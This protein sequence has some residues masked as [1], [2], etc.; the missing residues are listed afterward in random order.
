LEGYGGQVE[1]GMGRFGLLVGFDEGSVVSIDGE[2]VGVGVSS[3]DGGGVGMSSMDS[4]REGASESGIGV[5]A[6]VVL[7]KALGFNDGLP[8]AV[9]VGISTGDSGLFGAV[10][11]GVEVLT[12][13]VGLCGASAGLYVGCPVSNDGGSGGGDGISSMGSVLVGSA[14]LG[15]RD[16]GRLVGEE[17]R[18]SGFE[19][20]VLVGLTVAVVGML[21][22]M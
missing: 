20:P 21:F 6:D 1:G 14:E 4:V 19:V 12:G 10:G 13:H 17:G 22:G 15:R 11:A 3:I 8:V 18:E 5:G 9:D 2:G 7:G 16:D